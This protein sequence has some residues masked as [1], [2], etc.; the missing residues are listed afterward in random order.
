MS[1]LS[2][3][4]YRNRVNTLYYP[5]TDASIY[6]SDNNSSSDYES[7]LESGKSDRS[8]INLVANDKHKSLSIVSSDVN[9]TNDSLSATQIISNS[10]NTSSSSNNDDKLINLSFSTSSL[11][12]NSTNNTA[13]RKNKS[14]KHFYVTFGVK[15]DHQWSS[16]NKTHSSIYLNNK[17]G[18]ILHLYRH[19]TYYFHV[20][21]TNHSTLQIAPSY[22]AFMFTTSPCGGRNALL[23]ADGFHP[24]SQGI[25]SFQV[26]EQ[27]PRYFFYQN[28]YEELQ[29]GLVIVHD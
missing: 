22:N 18:P 21:S 13:S 10:T 20:N 14:I 4:A 16:Y 8:D 2:V 24:M 28:F 26:S 17:N 25:I 12:I 1:E 27:T 29:G 7:Q 3:K 11:L 6:G 5:S 9:I 19:V 23:I 15:H